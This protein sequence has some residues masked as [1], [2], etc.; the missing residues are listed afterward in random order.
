MTLGSGIAALQNCTWRGFGRTRWHATM[1]SGNFGQWNA[2]LNCVEGNSD[3]AIL[4]TFY[5]AEL[6]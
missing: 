3:R 2:N 6:F 1:S 5:K 4:V